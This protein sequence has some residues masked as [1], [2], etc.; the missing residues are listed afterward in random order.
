VV[1]N[2]DPG[3]AGLYLDDLTTGRQVSL[4][5]PP[6]ILNGKAVSCSA[7]ILADEYVV[8]SVGSRSGNGWTYVSIIPD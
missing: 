2:G 5:L 8:Y 4:E 1:Y 6:E 7:H 3:V